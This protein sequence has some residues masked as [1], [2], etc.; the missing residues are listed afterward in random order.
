[1]TEEIEPEDALLRRVRNDPNLWTEKEGQLRV[2]SAA[3]SPH[4]EDARLSVDARK[5]IPDPNDPLTAPCRTEGNADDGL[6]EFFARVALDLG[7][8]AHHDPQPG[9]AAHVNLTGFDSMPRKQAK[10]VQREL[11][12]SATWVREPAGVASA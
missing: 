6:A 10:R 7:L 11:A 3:M 5:L 12:K 8:A 1:M 2:S 4:P 9:D